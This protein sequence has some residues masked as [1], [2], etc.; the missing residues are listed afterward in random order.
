M[1]PK[2]VTRLL[3]MVLFSIWFFDATTVAEEG[4]ITGS[5]VL[6][7][8]ATVNSIPMSQSITAYGTVEFSPEYTRELS[9]RG[10]G[11]VT[12]VFVTA[13]EQV[14]KGT[15][16]ITVRP[17]ANAS[18]EI[19]SAR[20]AK[21]YSRKDLD[22]LISLRSSNLATN[23]EVQA[24]E[25]VLAKAE[26]ILANVSK[27]NIGNSGLTL[28]SEMNGVVESFSVKEGQI[29]APDVVLLHLADPNKLRVR[30]GVEVEDIEHVREGQRVDITPLYPGAS[31]VKGTI[32][33]V[34]RKV[35]P[36]TRLV[37]AV[38]PLKTSTGILPGAMVRGEIAIKSGVS[39]LA[40]PRESV[41]YKNSR[42]YVFVADKGKAHLRWVDAGEDNGKFVEI[43]KGLSAGEMVVTSGNY[44][45]DDGMAIRQESHK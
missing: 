40:I 24:A 34:Y 27:R 28:R 14:R 15:P 35:D 31:Q 26:A 42:A 18:L 33:Q 12:R 16:L 17:T 43:R 1:I 9:L 44:E 6:V 4:T 21:E 7:R 36:D 32:S 19:E 22:R 37:D 5:V 10:E 8:L 41:L 39:A 29:V 30:F 23:A 45:L 2:I 11:I 38:V 13:G 20:I 25:Q 3:L